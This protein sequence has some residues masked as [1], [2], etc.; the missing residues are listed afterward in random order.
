MK[1]KMAR[2]LVTLIVFSVLLGASYSANAQPAPTPARVAPRPV[3]MVAPRPAAMVP[4]MRVTPKVVMRV[5]RRAAKPAAKPVI[6][7]AVPAA[8]APTMEAVAPVMAVAP[9]AMVVTP[10]TT[11]AVPETKVAPAVKQDSKGSVVGG[12]LLQLLLYLVGILLAAFIPVLTAWVY[13][14]LK[15]T[16]LE[17]K[18]QIDGA[19]MKAAMFGIGKAEEAAYKLRDNPIDGAKKL[20]IAIK[21]ANQYLVD[22]GLPEKGA[23]YLADL[24]ESR[25]GLTRTSVPKTEVEKE[26]GVEKEEDAPKEEPKTE[27][28]PKEDD[29]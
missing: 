26:E 12:W 25:L 23:A 8:A 24:I 28:K 22:S 20:D 11:P 2:K 1:S 19:V 17:H 14:K 16:N 10:V 3:A 4:V 7:A 5:V 13:K 27:E 9:A 15:I 6:M 21:G 18:D 29:K